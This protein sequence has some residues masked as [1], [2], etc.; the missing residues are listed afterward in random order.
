MVVVSATGSSCIT[1]RPTLAAQSAKAGRSPKSPTPHERSE[2][3]EK[4][5]TDSPAAFH[6][7]SLTLSGSP[8]KTSASPSRISSSPV[9]RLSP[10]SHVLRWLV[11]SSTTT[12]LY[13][14]GRGIPSMLTESI[15]SPSPTGFIL[16]NRE[17]FQLPMAGWLPHTPTVSPGRSWGAATL[18]TMVLLKSE[19]LKTSTG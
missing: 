3:R 9:V 12:Y 17:G 16:R 18:K 6:C 15:H 13:S 11:L 19:S 7:G 8:Y 2:R 10:S 5:G 1:L 14:K 4:S